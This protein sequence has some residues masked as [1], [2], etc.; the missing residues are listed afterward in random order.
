MQQ[1]I[2]IPYSWDGMDYLP[3]KEDEETGRKIYG[4]RKY[5]IFVWGYDEQNDEV[6]WIIEDFMPW[7]YV[8]I[9]DKLEDELTLAPYILDALNTNLME[10]AR[11]QSSKKTYLK[12][13]LR[14]GKIIQGFVHEER[15]PMF[16]YKK[17]KHNL[18]K[19]FFRLEMA[20]TLC[21]EFL[22]NRKIAMPNGA[23]VAAKAY[24]NGESDRVPTVQKLIVE[25]EL[26]RCGWI[27]ANAV[28][29]RH[30]GLTTLD[31]EYKVSW[32]G[33]NMVPDII[34]LQLGFPKPS[35]LSIDAEVHSED[36]R[37][38]PK[39]A[40]LG[41]E[42]YAVGLRHRK[43]GSLKTKEPTLT[44]YI[45]VI[46]DA[47][48]NGE[49]NSFAD[50]YPNVV[51]IY[52]KNEMQLMQEIF[53]LIIRL[54]PSFILG[55]NTLGFDWDYIEQRCEVFGVKVPNMSRIR[56]WTRSKFRRTNPKINTRPFKFSY[57]QYHGRNDVDLFPLIV[58]QMFKFKNYKLKTVS[59]AIVGHNKIDLSPK[60]MFRLKHEGT[61]KGMNIIIDYLLTDI[62]L[63]DMLY[64]KLDTTMYLFEN[65]SVMNVN[66]IQLY[67]EG[68]SIRCI[69]Q[70]YKK[71]M[72]DGLYIDSRKIWKAGKYIGGMVFP[73]V[74]GIY[75]DVL[76]FDFS[77]LYPSCMKAK[78]ICYTS[79]IDEEVDGKDIPDEDCEIVEGD[80]PIVDKKTKEV[81]E[82]IHYKFR[83]IKKSIYEGLLPRIV[84]ELN[85]LRGRYKEEM[86][87][88][89]KELKKYMAELNKLENNGASEEEI[90]EAKEKVEYWQK[91][92]AK[93][94]VKNMATKVSAN[95]MYGFLGMKTGIYSFIEGGMS[96]TIEG[97]DSISTALD[98]I[99]KDYG[100]KLIYG[101]T[102]SVMVQFPEGFVN[103]TNYEQIVDE[104]GK[105]IS[106]HFHEDINIVFENYFPRFFTV[107]KKRYCG[108]KLDP[109]HPTILPTIEEIFAKNLLYMKGLITVRGNTC[110]IHSYFDTFILKMMLEATIDELFDFIHEMAQK[111][112]RRE[113]PLTDYIFSQKLNTHYKNPQTATMAIFADCLRQR[114]RVHE[115][116]EE[117]EYVYVKTYGKCK[118]GYMMQAPDLFVDN[119]NVLN[120][121]YYIT[122]C[123]S[124]PLQQ[125][126]TSV[127]GDDVLKNYEKKIIRPRKPT[128]VQK[129][130]EHWH[131]EKYIQVYV[132]GIHKQWETVQSE[133]KHIRA[134]AEQKGYLDY[135]CDDE[136]TIK[137][138]NE[139]YGIDYVPQG[140][141][142][143]IKL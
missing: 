28:L 9:E 31:K 127:Y 89:G 41:D 6:C 8:R 97:R 98:I 90:Q 68:Q 76:T 58:L 81:I 57:P 85:A 115:G 27:F 1:K 60:E 91:E 62:L 132:A 19:C 49:L 44:N 50:K 74:P 47:E 65:G 72:A 102:D 71:V 100:A 94:N 54:D 22:K 29:E 141:V 96:T 133:I 87:K 136:T 129:V 38:F 105:Y 108:I 117:L 25:K 134:I 53:L 124:K 99:V 139:R 84:T 112:C 42:M 92:K 40:K 5:R 69:S 111:I 43:W 15:R 109:N 70:L 78:N 125:L 20:M 32:T 103:P 86:G 37:S 7:L 107:T 34:S 24:H 110:G 116:G 142:V 128:S 59:K 17:V 14:E 140:K 104:I 46:W 106:S 118:V 131:L 33:L 55:Y 61:K 4:E 45:V 82:E 66:P 12:S 138:M 83:Y 119:G 120:T 63:P 16:Y 121:L 11:E 101:D 122:N 30:D 36:L 88:A 130:T 10:Y 21:Y 113:H 51:Y 52:C 77:S 3:V 67:I 35:T 135:V 56:N 137:A 126:L 48:E 80:V 123:L 79:K 114:G 18:Y 23:R 75:K 143:E 93:W 13:L 95:S 39:A 64:D 26:D 2:I 73:Q